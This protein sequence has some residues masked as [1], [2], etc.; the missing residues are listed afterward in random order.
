MSVEAKTRLLGAMKKRLSNTLTVFNMDQ[1][2]NVLADEISHYDINMIDEASNDTDDMLEA[3]LNALRV[4]GRSRK[5]IARYDYILKRMLS[6]IHLTSREVSVYDIRRYLSEEKARGISDET[7]EGYRQVYSA[8]FNWLQR[9]GL[10]TVNP[11]GNVGV[12]KTQKKIKTIYTETDI[13][14]LKMSCKTVRDKAILCFLRSTGCRISEVTE[15]NRD[16]IDF[17]NL[18]CKVLGKGNRNVLF[19]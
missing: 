11:I 14:K 17:T 1:L 10:I 15:L 9:E 6:T 13:E 8:Y 19:T 7:L 4:G 2:I 16:A 12:I 5:T 18:E 3:Y